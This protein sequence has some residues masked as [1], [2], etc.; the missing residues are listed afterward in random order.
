[1]SKFVQFTGGH[2]L[3]LNSNS[4]DNLNNRKQ[5]LNVSTNVE[6]SANSQDL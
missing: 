5:E 2:F 1:M 4:D 6:F 3:D